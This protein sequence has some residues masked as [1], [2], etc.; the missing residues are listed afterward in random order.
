MSKDAK[1][2]NRKTTHKRASSEQLSSRLGERVEDRDSGKGINREKEK[3]PLDK[4]E[5]DS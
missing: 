2:R 3:R 4:V 1:R 5:E